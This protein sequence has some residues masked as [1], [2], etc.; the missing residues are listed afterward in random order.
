MVAPMRVFLSKEY[1]VAAF[2][3]G[4]FKSEDNTITLHITAKR[5]RETA[6]T[7]KPICSYKIIPKDDRFVILSTEELQ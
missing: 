1:K 5:M 7:K 4:F 2:L 3:L 6:M